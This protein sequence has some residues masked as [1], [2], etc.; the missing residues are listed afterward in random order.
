MPDQ[1]PKKTRGVFERPPGSG[2]WWIHYYA[3]GKRHRER[4]GTKANAIK[5][6]DIRKG[7]AAAGRKLPDLRRAP[8]TLGDLIDDVLEHTAHHKGRREYVNKA[9]IVRAA[10]GSRVADEITPQELE[11]WLR[12]HC[13][14]A[15][16]SN[17]YKA[18]LSLCYREGI[19]NR[20]IAAN[21]ARQVRHRL[22]AAG[23]LRFLSREEY[24]RVLQALQELSPERVRDF[25]VSVNTGM[26]LSEQ[27]TALWNQFD[28]RRAAIELTR[29]KNGTQRTVHL[30]SEALEAVLSAPRGKPTEPIFSSSEKRYSTRYWFKPALAKAGIADYV[31]HG[32]RHTFCSWLAMAGASVKEIQDLAGHKSIVMSARYAHLSPNHMQSVVERIS[33][34]AEE[35]KATVPQG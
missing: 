6:R 15:A 3:G 11:R 16:T 22:E 21:P 25:V 17:R 2:I 28:Q 24:D 13:K 34:S 27:Y 4:V 35:V 26:R 12:S 5:L 8:V 29:T 32:N 14:T 1:E 31:W 20:G 10:L 33:R 7:D 18:F 9:G 23:R 30:N 19:T